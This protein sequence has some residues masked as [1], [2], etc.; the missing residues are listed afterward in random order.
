MTLGTIIDANCLHPGLIMIAM[1]LLVMALPERLRRPTYI[2]A[3]LLALACSLQLNESSEMVYR[4]SSKLSIDMISFDRLSL[5]FMTAFCIVSLIA[6]IYSAGS[7]NRFEMGFALMYAGSN[8]GV[9]L[10]GDVLSLIIF[11]ELSAI[12]SCYVVYAR[13]TRKSTRAAFRYILVHGFGGNMLLVGI[14]SYIAKYGMDITNITGAQDFTFWMIFIGVAVNAA[15]PPLNS[16]MPDAYPEST[17]GGTIYL[18]SFTTKSA[19]YVMIRFFAGTEWLVY[20]GAFMAIYGI[21][22]AL[23]ENDLRRLFCYHIIS[24]LGYIVA[25]L[26]MGPGYG[27]DGAAAH[28]FNNI[29]YKGTLL[30]CAGAVLYATGRRKISELGGLGRQMPLTAVCFLIASFAISGMP[31]LNGFASKALV[32]HAVSEGGYELVSFLLTTASVGTWMSIALKINYFVFFGKP[33]SGKPFP[34]EEL[35]SVPVNMKIGM[36]LG[37]AAC[38]VTGVMPKLV[39]NLTPSMTDGHPFTVE[40][41]VEYLVLFAGGTVIFF[42]FISKMKVHDQL[43][44]DFDWF[45]RVALDRFILWIS[46]SIHKLFIFFDKI[47]L[48]SCQYMGKHLGNPYLWTEKSQNRYIRS[49]SFENEDRLIGNVIIAIVFTFVVMLVVS[50]AVL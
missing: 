41:I 4:I 11:W 42:L 47:V 9:V 12:A 7:N 48:R 10:S 3:P 21:L 14:I 32:M 39:Y 2:V 17:I 27:I 37:A 6:A 45:Y 44:L 13:R 49:I 26:A 16:W 35:K 8:M 34:A 15:V 38:T 33:V 30:M 50:A 28:T 19:I 25:S 31:F 18:A 29:M 20:V 36:V 43:S 1:G 22:M 5:I 24:Q 46:T 23:L 40:H